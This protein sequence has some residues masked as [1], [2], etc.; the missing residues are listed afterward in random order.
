MIINGNLALQDYCSSTGYVS[1]GFIADSTVN[2]TVEFDGQQQYLIRNSDIG[3]SSNSVWNMVFSGVSGAPAT[4]F[5]GNG[6]QYTSI[7]ASPET[8]EEPFLT[9]D[10]RGAFRVF[11]PAV[12]RKSSGTSWS[13]GHRGG[14]DRRARRFLVANPRT[15]LATIN[16]ALAAGRNLMLTPGVYDLD[17][18]IVISR[19]NTVV[20]G[21]GFATLV[22][23]HGEAAMVVKSDYGVKLSGLLIDGGPVNSPV[24]LEVGCGTGLWSTVAAVLTVQGLPCR[25]PPRAARV[26]A[27]QISFKT[28]FF[29]SAARGLERQRSAFLIT[30]ATRSST[31]FGRGVRTTAIP[32][33]PDGPSIR[34][35]PASS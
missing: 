15:S 2:G 8:E 3:G 11:V 18:P 31:T 17:H 16:A 23:Q 22:P 34:P 24:L 19:P 4:V 10:S 9:V 13:S 20:M 7:P 27:T 32:V 14:D 5:S 25:G 1:G 6:H 28:S 33:R 35:L 26:E 29:A 30:P 21:M 12:R